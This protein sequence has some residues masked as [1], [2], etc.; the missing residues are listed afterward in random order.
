MHRVAACIARREHYVDTKGKI[1]VAAAFVAGVACEHWMVSSAYAAPAVV[2]A[3]SFVLKDPAG[4]TRAELTAEPNGRPVLKFY[5]E[6]GRT[7]WAAPDTM[8]MPAR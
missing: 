5:D 3:R 2:A 7:V 1:A 6:N 8:L 4:R